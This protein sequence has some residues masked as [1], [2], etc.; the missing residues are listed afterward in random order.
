[1]AQPFAEMGRV[2]AQFADLSIVT[3]D[4]PRNEDP[5]AIVGDIERGMGSAP[6]ER[7]VDRREAIQRAIELAK[8]EDLVLLAGK[9]HETYQIWGNEYRPFD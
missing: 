7:I 6:R 1:M 8:P 4:N 9:G 2:A 3:S 5:I